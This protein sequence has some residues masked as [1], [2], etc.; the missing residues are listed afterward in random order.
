LKD[1]V[2]CVFPAGTIPQ[3]QSLVGKTLNF[4]VTAI[5]PTNTE[6]MRFIVKGLVPTKA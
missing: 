5:R 4:V 2:D 3:A 1:T 6:R